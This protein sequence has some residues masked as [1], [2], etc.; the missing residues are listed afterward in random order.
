M[1]SIKNPSFYF[2]LD[3]LEQHGVGRHADRT[4]PE[5][6]R[7]KLVCTKSMH[8]NPPFYFEL[9]MVELQSCTDTVT[10]IFLS[11]ADRTSLAVPMRSPTQRTRTVLIESWDKFI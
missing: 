5:P 1:H 9:G 10:E 11:R 8:T 6:R 3:L 4:F 2:V 7:P